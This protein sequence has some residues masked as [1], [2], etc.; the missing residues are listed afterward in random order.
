MSWLIPEVWVSHSITISF[1]PVTMQASCSLCKPIASP[2]GSAHLS[3]PQSGTMLALLLM[4]HR[5]ICQ[6]YSP[7]YPHPWNTTQI[8]Q[9]S[10]WSCNFF[11]CPPYEYHG[12]ILGERWL[13]SWLLHAVGCKLPQSMPR[14]KYRWGLFWN[15]KIRN[16]YLCV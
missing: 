6:S 16:S 1:F 5:F 4:L 15:T 7:C 11:P 14:A 10:F 3:Q 13:S 2:S 12:L 8:W 9:D